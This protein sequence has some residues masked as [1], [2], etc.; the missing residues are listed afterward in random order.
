[1]KAMN[2]KQFQVLSDQ[3]IAELRSFVQKGTQWTGPVSLTVG[4]LLET[5]D[6]TTRQLKLY[7][8]RFDYILDNCLRYGGGNGVQVHFA[9][10]VDHEDLG[11]AISI[12]IEQNLSEPPK[13]KPWLY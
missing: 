7:Q 12:A 5:L 11:C 3:E 8:G 9:V 1:M 2:T 10:P 13:I 4:R 6:D